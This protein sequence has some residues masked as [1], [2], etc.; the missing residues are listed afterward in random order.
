MESVHVKLEQFPN[1]HSFVWDGVEY[2]NDCYEEVYDA[3]NEQIA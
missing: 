3:R 2:I 1:L